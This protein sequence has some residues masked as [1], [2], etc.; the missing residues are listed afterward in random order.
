MNI[1]SGPFTYLIMQKLCILKNVEMRKVSM[2]PTDSYVQ[3]VLLYDA[4]NP[5]FSQE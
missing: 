1:K 5:Q 3:I 4:N 2:F